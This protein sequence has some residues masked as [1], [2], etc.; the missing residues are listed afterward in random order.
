MG[1]TWVYGRIQSREIPSVK[2]EH[3]IK[4]R[5]EELEITWRNTAQ[6]PTIS[7]PSEPELEQDLEQETVA[8]LPSCCDVPK[9][10]HPGLPLCSPKSLT[11]SSE[12][13]REPAT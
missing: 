1:K 10:S 2:L 5:R 4:V 6:P 11:R 3:K 9:P 8:A 12:N 13:Q 7:E